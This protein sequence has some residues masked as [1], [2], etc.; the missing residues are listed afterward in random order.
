MDYHRR[1]I[2]LK[3]WNY[4][5][6]G[7]YF[8]TICSFERRQM[9]GAIING[10]MISNNNGLIIEN[11]LIKLEARFDLVMDI[12]QIMPNHI[13]LILII[14]NVGA[15][16]E[17]PKLINGSIRK[18]NRAIHESPLPKRSMLSKIIGYLKMNASREIGMFVWQR[19]YYEH[20][21]RNEIELKKIREYIRMNPI[22]WE[23]DRNNP[24]NF[25]CRGDS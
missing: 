16:H 25:K 19:N 8:I 14:K 23:R 18:L 2:R 5:G 3:K 10:K 1:S 22:M 4:S 6:G 12:F 11:W 17:S 13:H 20:I 9:F 15:I 21:V 7:Y 24:K